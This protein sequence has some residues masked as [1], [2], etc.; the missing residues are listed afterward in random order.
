[1]DVADLSGSHLRLA[2]T[3]TF[4]AYLVGPL[5]A[6]LHVRHPG[7]TVDVKELTQDRIEAGLL[8]DAL[9]HDH[10][11][12]TPIPLAPALLARTVCLLQRDSAYQSAATRA[13]TD[14]TRHHVSARGYPLVR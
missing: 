7:I 8:A 12:L 10:P 2:V 1:M 14:L 5:V 13:F 3:P 11:G 6:D 9:A 4:T